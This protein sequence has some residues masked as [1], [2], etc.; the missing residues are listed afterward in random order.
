MKA[1]RKGIVILFTL[2]LGL[3]VGCSNTA[4]PQPKEAPTPAPQPM[5]KTQKHWDKPP[6]M[7]INANKTYQATISTNKGDMT[8][9]LFAKNAPQTV[10]NFVFLS[11]QHF[12]DQLIFHRII[13]SFMIQTG[14]PNGNGSGG[15]GYS[16]PDELNSPYKYEKGIV[17][18]ANAGPNT[19]GSQFFICS[20]PDS[21]NLNAAPN[22][23][24]FGKVTSGMDTVDKIA[25]VPVKAGPTG[26]ESE[27]TA[28]VFIKTITITEK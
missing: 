6:A 24:I 20:G 9:D 26:E 19:N 15:P 12:Y 14:D 8:I 23:T 7:A 22:Y 13:K 25:S 18:M 16:F 1:M 5:A 3:I 2:L 10:N 21:S 27:P 28:K 11:K 17:A 4:S